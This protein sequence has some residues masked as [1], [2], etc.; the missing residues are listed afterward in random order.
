MYTRSLANSNQKIWDPLFPKDEQSEN[1]CS[2]S[3]KTWNIHET[4]L[5]AVFVD[6]WSYSMGKTKYF[7]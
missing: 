6:I 2:T 1:I 3:S 4:K 7:Q 5:K